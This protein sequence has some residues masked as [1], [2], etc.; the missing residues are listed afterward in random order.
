M[1]WKLDTF[2]SSTGVKVEV[3][4]S[5]N[6]SF[7][8]PNKF[9]GVAH[10]MSEYGISDVRFEIPSSSVEE[11]F[12]KYDEYLKIFSDNMKK[13][14]EERQSKLEVPKPELVVPE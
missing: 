1:Y 8:L 10:M 9:V 2:V 12:E 11:A 7:N 13:Q 14:M 4:K 6:D 3:L 5:A